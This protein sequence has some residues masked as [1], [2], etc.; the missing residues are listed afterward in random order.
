MPA[1]SQKKEIGL[2]CYDTFQAK[3]T[4]GSVVMCKF[5][6]HIF[7]EAH[8]KYKYESKNVFLFYPHEQAF[9]KRNLQYNTPSPTVTKHLF[10]RLTVEQLSCVFQVTLL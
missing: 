4:Q 6:I 7:T 1:D 8:V 10:T 9:V 3:I 5:R 2:I